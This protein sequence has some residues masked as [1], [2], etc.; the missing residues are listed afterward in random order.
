MIGIRKSIDFF[1]QLCLVFV[2]FF[3]NL[4]D[5]AFKTLYYSFLLQGVHEGPVRAVDVQETR[6]G[7]NILLDIEKKSV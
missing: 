2:H 5:I 6:L 3:Y 7:F 4:L 1:I